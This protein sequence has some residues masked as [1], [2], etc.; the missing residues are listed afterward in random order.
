MY[1]C[2]TN[3]QHRRHH[4]LVCV[5]LKFMTISLETEWDDEWEHKR[6]G[7]RDERK[8]NRSTGNIN[9]HHHHHLLHHHHLQQQQ[10]PFIE[11][12]AY[13]R[14]YATSLGGRGGEQ[15]FCPHG[16]HSLPEGKKSRTDNYNEMRKARQAMLWWLVL[17]EQ[18]TLVW[19]SSDCASEA[20]DSLPLDTRGISRCL[21]REEA[22]L[23][24]IHVLL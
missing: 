1:W 16:A 13:V 22:G 19:F 5:T 12:L 21:R 11:W 8:R 3:S 6:R 4:K 2:E 23:G 9:H 24:T 18:M 7:T 20:H 14:G 17:T 15:G 10:Q